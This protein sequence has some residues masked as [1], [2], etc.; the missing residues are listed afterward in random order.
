MKVILFCLF[1]CVANLIYSQTLSTGLTAC[2]S[3]SGN[4]SDPINSLNGTL[5][6]VT[7]T[8]DRFNI[9]N[10]AYQFNGTS[11][12]F[13]E[14]P[15]NPLLKPTN[16]ISFSAWIKMSS[17]SAP[18]QYVVFTK[19][20]GHPYIESYALVVQIPG[21]SAH[22]LRLMKGDGFGNS[23]EFYGNTT[24]QTNTWYHVAFTIDNSNLKL[25]L[26]GVLE[27]S[28]NSTH[29]FNYMV[30][31]N[32]YLGGSNFPPYEFPLNGTI[33][34]ARFY[35]R[36]LSANEVN[37]LYNLDPACT[38]LVVAPTA[39]FSASNETVC[40]S[41][42]VVLTDQSTQ[43]PTSWNWQTPGANTSS[44]SINNP[45][46][47]FSSPGNYS[48][49]LTSSNSVGASNTVTKTIV[50]NPNP[51]A[52]FSY[53]TNPC[54][55]GVYFTDL[56]ESEIVDWQ[57]TFTST[58]SSLLQNPYYFY[59][60]GGIYPVKLTSTN[61]YGCKHS[62][63]QTITI[64][65]PPTLSINYSLSICKG[66]TV[67][68]LADGGS[69]YTWTPNQ[70][71]NYSNVSNPIANPLSS[72]EYSVM[73]TTTEA[74]GS[75]TCDYLL[76]TFVEV[77]QLSKSHLSVSADPRTI[78]AGNPSTLIYNGDLGAHVSWL[79]ET[80]PSIGYT[81]QA[82]PQ[83]ST[84]YTVTTA[85][86]ACTE[87]LLVYVEA[88]TEGCGDNDVFVPNTFTPNNDSKND[89]LY[90]R[91]IKVTDLYFAVYNRWGEL[92]FET[93]DKTQGWDGTYKNKNVDVGVFG[94]YLRVKCING[95]E[96]I[97]KGNVT[98][99]R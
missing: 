63:Q 8:V 42:N 45:T 18:V 36:V 41:Q 46:I 51:I 70:Q 38:N 20:N 83:K 12:S 40:V 48:V 26:N 33:D 52:D 78:T 58:N 32:V 97:K 82:Y 73:I 7:P 31:K 54:G 34:N 69:S 81:V 61:I 88:Y 65:N 89:V 2:Y 96:T 62:I 56:S 66:D 92:V 79:P 99:M 5:S 30:G 47:S 19:N 77:N 13:I 35:N 59:N 75:I 28:M 95:E 39:S 1:L 80:I 25:Y 76:T 3:F 29:G 74:T 23:N 44:S 22:K 86:G 17:L 9:A 11:N 6:N 53:S 71:L 98:L 50:V 84:T 14:L 94:W 93:T 60:N 37:Q 57:W 4:A 91:G 85:L 21:G 55:G 43:N 72:T 10:S 87:T 16:A 90:V 15:D 68:L 49:S 24:I 64:N 67:Q 27:G